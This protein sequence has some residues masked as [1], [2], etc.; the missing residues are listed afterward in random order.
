LANGGTLF[1]DEIGEML[2]GVQAKLLRVL[3]GG[4]VRRVGAVAWVE[5]DVRV[6]AATNRDLLGEVAAGRFRPDLFYRL[7]V[8]RIKTVPLRERPEDI[9]LLAQ[10]F[11][12][13]GPHGPRA[14]DLTALRALLAHDWPGNVRELHN[15][16][17]RAKILAEGPETTAGDLP[18]EVTHRPGPAGPGGEGGGRRGEPGRGGEAIP[19]VGAGLPGGEQDPGGPEF[20]H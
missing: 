6:I 2:P 12:S 11:L 14:L 13:L 15:A 1:I 5:T 7:N 17:R 8:F 4:R 10:H 9:P 3:E 19:A 20:G 18:E 16:I